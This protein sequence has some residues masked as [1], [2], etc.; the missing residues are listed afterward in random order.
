MYIIAVRGFPISCRSDDMNNAS[1]FHS[2]EFHRNGLTL[3]RLTPS[4]GRLSYSVHLSRKLTRHLMAALR[5]GLYVFLFHSASAYAEDLQFSCGST[6][7]D[8]VGSLVDRH[9]IRSKPM[10]VQP[11]SVNAFR[12]MHHDLTAFG[13]RV[14][15]ILGYQPDDPLFVP[16]SGTPSAQ[17]MYG[18]VV[19]ASQDD[20]QSRL[21]QIGMKDATVNESIP[22]MTAVLCQY[23]AAAHIQPGSGA[24]AGQ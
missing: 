12:P 14:I 2:M 24:A 18:A 17:S 11:N 10:H 9:D 22:M 21:S 19:S 20:V 7:H 8:F 6:A 23:P 3:S 13:F 16:G 4:R 1:L 15:A 5:I